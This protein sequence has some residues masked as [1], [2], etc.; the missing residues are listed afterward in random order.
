MALHPCGA[1]S[2]GGSTAGDVQG[3]GETEKGSLESR[4]TLSSSLLIAEIANQRGVMREA[5]AAIEAVILKLHIEDRAELAV[6]LC[7]LTYVLKGG[8]A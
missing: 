2:T 6:A 4:A 5:K 7:K 1:I 3:V 8:V